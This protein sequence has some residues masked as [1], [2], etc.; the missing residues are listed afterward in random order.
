MNGQGRIARRETAGVAVQGMQTLM[1]WRAAPPATP[2]V[3]DAGLKLEASGRTERCSGNLILDL[4]E[5]RLEHDKGVQP[6]AQR[7]RH[8]C[9]V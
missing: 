5:G 3:V 7:G 8:G 4:F 2:K 1:R 9:V 6:T